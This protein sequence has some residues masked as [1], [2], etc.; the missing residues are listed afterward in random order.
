MEDTDEAPPATPVS[1][2]RKMSGSTPRKTP[3]TPGKTAAD[4]PRFYPLP[5]KKEEDPKDKKERKRKK[6]VKDLN[7]EFDE[8]EVGW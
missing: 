3:R 7:P 6:K 4:A 2:P 5:D 8:K 1:Q